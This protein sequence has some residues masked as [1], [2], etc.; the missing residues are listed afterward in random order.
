MSIILLK[1]GKRLKLEP[2]SALRERKTGKR[3]SPSKQEV[4]C[5]HCGVDL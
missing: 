3:I 5:G 4:L 2:R 1:R